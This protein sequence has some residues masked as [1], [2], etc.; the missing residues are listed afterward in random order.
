MKNTIGLMLG[1]CFICFACQTEQLEMSDKILL[2]KKEPPTD[3]CETSFAIGNSEDDHIC[4][5][6]AGFN[7]WGWT[8]GPLTPGKYTYDIY[9][10]A[11]QCDI[12][13]GQFTGTI[14]I[15]YDGKNI[16]AVYDLTSG[17]SNSETHLYAGTAPFP[18]KRNGR[19]TV[20]P[21]QYSVQDDLNGEAIYIIA[22]AVTCEKDDDDDDDENDSFGSY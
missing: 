19:Y 9:A 11:G 21:G 8:I 4:F 15:S 13:R 3:F 12:L 20:A 22:H 16:T 6:E 10:G 17:Y 7:R 5:S 18:T 2:E 1:L 14:T